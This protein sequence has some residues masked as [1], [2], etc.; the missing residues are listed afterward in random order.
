M[1]HTKEKFNLSWIF[2]QILVQQCCCIYC[3]YYCTLFKTD[4]TFS[5]SDSKKGNIF[6]IPDVS[7]SYNGDT[8]MCIVYW[9]VLLWVLNWDEK[10]KGPNCEKCIHFSCIEFFMMQHLLFE[11]FEWN[12]VFSRWILIFCT[13]RCFS[14]WGSTVVYLLQMQNIQ[15]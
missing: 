5:I 15:S 7:C 11:F 12:V 10:E 14:E 9:R 8:D 6:I 1:E 13:I 3:M 4:E 2:V